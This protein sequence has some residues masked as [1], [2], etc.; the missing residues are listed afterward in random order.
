M[1]VSDCLQIS[2]AKFVWTTMELLFIQIFYYLCKYELIINTYV[3]KYVCT[4]IYT[5]IIADPFC[6]IDNQSDF[7]LNILL[8]YVCMYALA[9]SL[10]W[11][12]LSPQRDYGPLLM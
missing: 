2:Q 11:P 12:D 4:N 9:T 5:N 10:A 6:F 7:E 3:Y 8:V 1:L